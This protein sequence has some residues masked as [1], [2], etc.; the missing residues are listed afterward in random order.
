VIDLNARTLFLVW[1][2]IAISC[3]SIFIENTFL[4]YWTPSRNRGSV[5]FFEW[6]SLNSYLSFLTATVVYLLMTRASLTRIWCF[7]LG[8]FGFFALTGF[9]LEYFLYFNAHELEKEEG[10]GI[11]LGSFIIGLAFA[12]A[13]TVSRLIIRYFTHK[14]PRMPA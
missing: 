13:A 14:R 3:L 2:G 6:A 12:F 10:I 1:L 5:S 4:T 8:A 7:F 11:V 9:L